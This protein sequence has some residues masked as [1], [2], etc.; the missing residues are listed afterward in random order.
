MC[1]LASLGT[2]CAR[3]GAAN[4][5]TQQLSARQ[6]SPPTVLFSG[7]TTTWRFTTAP[8]KRDRPVRPCA[9]QGGGG[10]ERRGEAPGK[11]PPVKRKNP[12]KARGFE[13]NGQRE[14]KPQ[15]SSPR[16]CSLAPG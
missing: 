7:L 16:G 2:S 6:A 10:R 11:G 14:S 4:A 5:A 9:G 3:A 8:F 1:Q 13:Q 12:P 15:T